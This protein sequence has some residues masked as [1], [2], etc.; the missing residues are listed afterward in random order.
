MEIKDL[1]L[2]GDDIV[3]PVNHNKFLLEE[4]KNLI[5][6]Y[7]AMI[8][9]VQK[10][11]EEL[12]I[13]NS[14]IE[15]AIIKVILDSGSKSV[16]FNGLRLTAKKNPDS[17]EIVDEFMV[18]DKYKSSKTTEK[19]DKRHIMEDYNQLGILADGVKIK[20]G[21]YTLLIKEKPEQKMNNDNCNIMEFDEDE[22]VVL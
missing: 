18:P 15:A 7:R 16:D 13:A 20:T 8:K 4:K 17:V 12:E 1:I 21:N 11:I 6:E 19:I 2:R 10:E 5:A 3:A 22:D 14:K 9:D